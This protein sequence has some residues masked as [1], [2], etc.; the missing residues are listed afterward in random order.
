MRRY[1]VLFSL[2][3]CFSFL[4]LSGCMSPQQ[5]AAKELERLRI[6]FTDAAMV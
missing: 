1:D 5:K 2:V 6:P 3:C 4:V